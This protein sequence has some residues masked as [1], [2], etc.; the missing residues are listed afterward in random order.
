MVVA[1]DRAR[2]YSTL[3]GLDLSSDEDRSATTIDTTEVPFENKSQVPDIPENMSHLSSIWLFVFFTKV[4]YRKR[5]HATTTV[6]IPILPDSRLD[7]ISRD[8]SMN[9]NTDPY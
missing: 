8:V 7:Q 1:D 6:D 5:G 9:C 4:M 3:T 2:D